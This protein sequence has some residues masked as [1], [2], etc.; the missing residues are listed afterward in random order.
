MTAHAGGSFDVE[1]EPM[2]ADAGTDTIGRRTMSKQ[3]HGDLDA[4]SVGQMLA[5]GT[6]VQG[7]AGYVAIEQVTGSLGGRQGGFLLQHVGVMTRGKGHLRIEVIPDSGT[8][9]LVGLTGSM[10]I[11]ITDG[12]HFYDLEYTLPDA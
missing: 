7:S 6:A 9:Q 1:L 5:A 10:Q 8:H 12:K 2:P 11:T 3:Y 4:T